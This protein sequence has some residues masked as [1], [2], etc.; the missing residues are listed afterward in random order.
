MSNRSSP[1]TSNKYIMFKVTTLIYILFW[2]SRM[3]FKSNI[4]FLKCSQFQSFHELTIN[5]SCNTMKPSLSI[6]YR[7]KCHSEYNKYNILPRVTVVSCSWWPKR[8]KLCVFDT[9]V[10][11]NPPPKP[12]INFTTISWFPQVYKHVR[13]KRFNSELQWKQ[14]DQPWSVCIYSILCLR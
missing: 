6:P 9:V 1:L 8:L 11:L 10:K 7:P 14:K 13:I 5:V 3:S 2:F 12:D 4:L